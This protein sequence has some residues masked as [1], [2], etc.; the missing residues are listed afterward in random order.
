MSDL[1][2]IIEQETRR[3]HDATLIPNL[4]FQRFYSLPPNGED[5]PWIL[6]N[7]KEKERP[8]TH[9]I[10]DIGIYDLLDPPHRHTEEKI[11]A[12]KS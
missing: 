8:A 4:G 12:W 7:I 9:E 5:Y 2:E 6:R 11:K 1:E 3:Q 10:V